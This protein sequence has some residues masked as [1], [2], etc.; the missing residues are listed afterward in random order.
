SVYRCL[1]VMGALPVCLI[2]FSSL[3]LA[4]ST[5]GNLYSP[6]I[7]VVSPEKGDRTT[8]QGLIA[9]EGLVLSYKLPLA[10]VVVY[11]NDTVTFK[12]KLEPPSYRYPFRVEVKLQP[13]QNV[14]TIVARNEKSQSK[15]T[16]GRIVYE[17]KSSSEKPK[18]AVL[19]I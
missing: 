14:V 11:V 8:R 6:E 3:T 18:V 10:D 13:G 9:F 19:A 2:V 4:Q 1:I 15:F 17:P 16:S 5:S 12:K 7:V